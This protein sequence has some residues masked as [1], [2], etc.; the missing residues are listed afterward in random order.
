VCAPVQEFTLAK[1]RQH[2]AFRDNLISVTDPR[3]SHLNL[4]RKNSSFQVMRVN[5]HQQI[6]DHVLPGLVLVGGCFQLSRPALEW[7]N[8]RKISAELQRNQ[9]KINHSCIQANSVLFL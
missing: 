6:L 9:K 3:R 2:L 8:Q 4:K 5:I 1:L 7:K